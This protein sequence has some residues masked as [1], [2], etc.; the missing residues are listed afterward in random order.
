ML[1]YFILLNSESIEVSIKSGGDRCNGTIDKRQQRIVSPWY[2]R[3][4]GPNLDCQWLLKAPLG[5]K[6][7]LRFESFKTEHCHDGLSIYDG[8]TVQWWKPQELRANLC[9]NSLP[10]DVVST[11]NVVLVRFS[12]DESVSARGFQLAYSLK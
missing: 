8:D 4:Y 11:E 5:K 10:G 6:L 12:S 1:K 2:P 3:S 7:S 9:G